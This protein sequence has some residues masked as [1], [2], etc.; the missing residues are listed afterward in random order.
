MSSKDYLGYYKLLGVSPSAT[1]N[2]IKAAY[3]QKAM[4]LHPDRNPGKNTT[5]AFQEL[6]QA[7]NV[8]LDDKLRQ[9]YDA[10]SSIPPSRTSEDEG[11]HKPFEPIVCSVCST[12]TAQP[13]YKVFYS[14]FGWLFGATKTPHQGI[15]CSKCEIKAGLKASALTLLTGWWSV[16][17][18]FW[19]ILTL[20]QNLVGGRFYLQNAQLQGYQAMYF[21]SVGKDDL[22][23][24]VAKSALGLI[25][26]AMSK[27][28]EEYFTHKRE[29]GNESEYPLISLK[30]T[31]MAYLGSFPE[32]VKNVEFKVNNVV[33]NKRF[34]YQSLLLAIFIGLVSGYVQYLN[35]QATK[36][37]KVRLEQLGIETDKAAAIAAEE[38]EA[39]KSLEQPLPPSGIFKVLDKQSYEKE[40]NPP[41]KINNSPDSN[42]LVKLIRVSDGAEVMS[43]FIRANESVELGV[44]PG[45]YQVKVASG[46]TWYG[47]AVRFGPNTSYAVLEK[48]FTFKVEGVQLMGHELSLTQVRH[49]NLRQSPLGAKDF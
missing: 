22:A 17:G 20:I 2:E 23:R 47:D 4:K 38:A 14:V 16:A 48:P 12:V 24:A 25:E 45:T 5:A 8:L 10:D 34:L 21:A 11:A 29:M 15:F 39:L 43:I 6:Q 49:G 3:R 18:F 26:K 42:S 27:E 13:R 33:F 44:P 46:Q 31:L 40:S 19:T 37:E 32:T 41:L 7:Y 28:Q 36:E 30:K 9:Q 1:T 35:I